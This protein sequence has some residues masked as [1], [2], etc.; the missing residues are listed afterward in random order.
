M[1]FDIDKEK[2]NDARVE[3]QKLI[4]RLYIIYSHHD[5]QFIYSGNR[6][7]HVKD[8]DFVCP[9]DN[10]PIKCEQLM[11]V[12]KKKMTLEISEPEDQGIEAIDIDAP[13][14]YNTRCIIRLPQSIHGSTGNLVEII[15]ENEIN[16]FKPK[17]ILKLS[18]LPK[19]INLSEDIDR[20]TKIIRGIGL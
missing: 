16:N 20:L 4:E 1:Y 3:L 14:S 17:R 10:N 13:I 7:F 9:K 18:K 5:L 19:A 6:G 15:N 12:A 2:L 11:G 8:F